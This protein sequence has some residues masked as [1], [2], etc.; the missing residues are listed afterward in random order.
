MG[1][2]ETAE[3]ALNLRPEIEL[4]QVYSSFDSQ[5]WIDLTRFHKVIV[6]KRGFFPI[7]LSTSMLVLSFL[8]YTPQR[9]AKMLNG[10]E[11]HVE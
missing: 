2:L 6:L 8:F 11:R 3:D 9:P 7:G 5:I 4:F 10:N 1:G